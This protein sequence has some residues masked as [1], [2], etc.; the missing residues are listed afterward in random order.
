[1]SAPSAASVFPPR[2]HCQ[3]PQCLGDPLGPCAFFAVTDNNMPRAHALHP[4]EAKNAESQAQPRNWARGGCS[5]SACGG[6]YSLEP[7][8]SWGYTTLCVCGRLL[9]AHA[10]PP[11][12]ADAGL[13]SSILGSA[14]PRQFSTTHP[15]GG[16]VPPTVPP[17]LPIPSGAVVTRPASSTPMPPPL[18]AYM[19]GRSTIGALRPPNV[20]VARTMIVPVAPPATADTQGGGVLQLHPHHGAVPGRSSTTEV[21]DPEHE[22]FSV[23][24]F[25]FV[26][27]AYKRRANGTYPLPTIVFHPADFKDVVQS[28][29]HW[30]LLFPV[31]L[32]RTGSVF[33]A[34]GTQV[35]AQLDSYGIELPGYERSKP[36]AAPQ[37]LPFV[38]LNASNKKDDMKLHS[39]YDS[40]NEEEFTHAGLTG[41][42]PN[43]V[44][45]SCPVGGALMKNRF[46]R[47]A[48]RF[49]DLRAPLDNHPAFVDGA[50]GLQD[51]L[52]IPA[53]SQPH[54][55]FPHR[56]LSHVVEGL[57]ARCLDDCPSASHFTPPCSPGTPAAAD[58][59]LDRPPALEPRRHSGPVTRSAAALPTPISIPSPQPDSRGVVLDDTDSIGT[60]S[61]Q[62]PASFLASLS[63]PRID[64]EPLFLPLTALPGHPD[65]IDDTAVT[66]VVHPPESVP[67]SIT[68]I[69]HAAGDVAV[70][71][72]N[73]PT[74]ATPRRPRTSVRMSTGSR[75]PRVP[76]D[77]PEGSPDSEMRD[78]ISFEAIRGSRRPHS[79]IASPE[80][81]AAVP[82][83]N[84]RR[85]ED[86]RDD[87]VNLGKHELAGWSDRVLMAI[88]PAS[89]RSLGLRPKIRAKNVIQ[90]AN[91]LV[92]VV[93]WLF[94]HPTSAPI[95]SAQRDTF[96]L[97]LR[98]QFPDPEVECQLVPLAEILRHA[99]HLD[100]EVEHAIGDSP[101]CSILR[102][103]I[104][105][106]TSQRGCWQP[107]GRYTTITWFLKRGV[108]EERDVALRTAGFLSLLHL[109]LWLVGPDP[110]SPFA[111]LNIL[112][113]RPLTCRYDEA[114]MLSMD[115]ELAARMEPWKSFDIT[116]PL[117]RDPTDPLYHLLVAAEIDPWKFGAGPLST[118]D[119]QAV[120]QDLVSQMVHGK[121][122]VTDDEL[123]MVAF[124]DG[125]F[126]AHPRRSRLLETF[127]GFERDYI[128]AMCNQRL[129]SVD[130][131]LAHL[132]FCPAADDDGMG[133]ED[134]VVEVSG[135]ATAGVLSTLPDSVWDRYFES[136]FEVALR[137]Y[138][139]QSGHP[140]VPIIRT[141]AGNRF[142]TEAGDPLLRARLFL[143]L[144][145]GSKLVP[146]EP[147]W[148]IK[149]QV[150]ACYLDC[151][152]TMDD[153]LRNVLRVEEDEPWLSFQAWFHGALL[154]P[155][156]FNNATSGHRRL[157]NI[158]VRVTGTSQAVPVPHWFARAIFT[159]DSARHVEVS[160]RALLLQ[161]QGLQGQI[162][163]YAPLL[164]ELDDRQT[165]AVVEAVHD[166]LYEAERAVEDRLRYIAFDNRHP[167]PAEDPLTDLAPREAP[168]PSEYDTA[169][170]D[171]R[172]E[173]HPDACPTP[174]WPWEDYWNGDSSDYGWWLPL[175]LLDVD[176]YEPDW[177]SQ[178]L[179][180]LE[181]EAQPEL[182]GR[183]EAERIWQ[184]LQAYL[185]DLQD[186]LPSG[187]MHVPGPEARGGVPAGVR[188]DGLCFLVPEAPSVTISMQV[189]TASREVH[190]S[191]GTP[192]PSEPWDLPTLT[193]RGNGVI[194][195]VDN[196]DE[197]RVNRLERLTLRVHIPDGDHAAAAAPD[198]LTIPF[199]ARRQE[200]RPWRDWH[201]FDVDLFQLRLEHE[202][203][204]R[205]LHCALAYFGARHCPVD[206]ECVQ[207][208][209]HGFAR[210]VW[211]IA[212][213]PEHP[214]SARVVVLGRW[215]RENL[216]EEI[217]EHPWWA[218]RWDWSPSPHPVSVPLEEDEGSEFEF[219]QGL[220]GLPVPPGTFPPSPWSSWAEDAV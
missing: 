144:M 45:I 3:H 151:L 36:W 114:F 127:R 153:G 12:A 182:A 26:P 122:V 51:L 72:S 49:G 124:R 121:P 152:I 125:F 192:E 94:A 129:D 42:K 123:D 81:L 18:S 131:L 33:R 86:G 74:D 24:V 128:A 156:D 75:A 171:P 194:V 160:L 103:A 101:I 16:G 220:D 99:R 169:W 196:G 208:Q 4:E 68:Q 102:H 212:I 34:L 150:Q 28:L 155:D 98:E 2:E 216:T 46:L 108:R 39:P 89:T 35:I 202:E 64:V 31:R 190:Y 105:L 10:S 54:K 44:G 143:T 167:S 60:E 69:P 120:E 183:A 161:L 59:G 112:V 174:P 118:G 149:I 90:G 198:I 109:V 22:T 97:A 177:P 178:V 63:Q 201:P 84:R 193:A 165:I 76:V 57:A 32:S 100:I 203:A 58:G 93:T 43:L 15:L 107:L 181:E 47:L 187:G 88:P 164:L 48:P 188:N 115:P 205:D 30:G 211:R 186:S 91:I 200:A 130:L 217:F 159:M 215:A 52:T 176:H 199:P 145:S 157:W 14:T 41:K 53:P 65:A 168:L 204:F 163:E 77:V 50:P 170:S 162:R 219:G 79:A 73:L 113:G 80:T 55:C 126:A 184:S 92:F 158:R 66:E 172:T 95:T 25:P 5:G 218:G 6:F 78:E 136:E 175:G 19:G 8:D 139:S 133:F 83:S 137:Y 179:L 40:F 111:L 106:I 213:E 140:D 1:M 214:A 189:V 110:I 87:T 206:E 166:R 197:R 29:E 119:L 116:Q 135:K 195:L 185:Q 134:D 71:V 21:P 27:P 141:M 209:W 23:L 56:V 67:S 70:D 9:R 154:E 147:A 13:C 37:D 104:R 38:L 146:I 61:P 148:K 180:E 117:P 207:R 20:I 132:D 7:R 11:D 96:E 85:V 173:D 17:G 62:S 138:L 210:A 142:D 82:P 191:W